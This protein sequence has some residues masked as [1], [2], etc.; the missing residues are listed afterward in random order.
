MSNETLTLLLAGLTVLLAIIAIVVAR[1]TLSYMRGRDLEVD[2]RNGWIEI[3]RAMIRLR[4]Q[5]AFIMLPNPWGPDPKD[6]RD[7]TLAA[8]QLRGQLDRLNDDPLVV[9]IASFLDDN[10]LTEKWQQP[11]YEKAFDT[12]VH[13]VAMKSRP[14]ESTNLLSFRWSN[15]MFRRVAREVVVFM[16]LGM[17]LVAIGSFIYLHHNEVVS[18]RN[19]TAAM[20]PPGPDAGS[21]ASQCIWLDQPFEPQSPLVPLSELPKSEQDCIRTELRNHL[22]N[23]ELALAASVFGLYGFA[24]GFGVWVFYRLVRFAV[25]G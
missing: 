12:F 10:V 11:Q 23:P 20:E 4:V 16:L 7:Y 25:T 6:S 22:N 17:L 5:R 18:I 3:H 2:T 15:S 8:A 24:G 1:E 19:R 13:K 9:E 14:T 21:S